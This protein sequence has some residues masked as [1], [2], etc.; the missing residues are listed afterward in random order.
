MNLKPRIED[1]LRIQA[2][3]ERFIAV[4]RERI[5]SGF[6]TGQSN[7]RSNYSIVESTPETIQV[8]AIGWRTAIN[9][10]LN[11]LNL[12]LTDRGTIHFRL[13]Y[14]RWSIYCLALCFAI[15]LLGT[16]LFLTIDIRDYISSHSGSRIPGLTIE[17]NMY[18]A[19]SNLVFWALI[20]PW[21]LI[22]FHKRPLRRL[23]VRLVSEID[24]AAIADSDQAS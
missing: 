10:G 12:D 4:L 2:S 8:R 1:T 9:I 6:L 7:S 22:A 16:L 20:W 3:S 17:Q 21:I 19:W 24:A 18:F 23:V 11:D 13:H 15:G 14:W 5:S